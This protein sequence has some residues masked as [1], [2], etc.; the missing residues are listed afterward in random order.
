MREPSGRER[1][2]GFALPI[3]LGTVVLL[4]SPLYSE[5]EW[6]LAGAP[7]ALMLIA[8]VVA[9]IAAP[10]ALFVHHRTAWAAAVVALTA[11]TVVSVVAMERSEHSTNALILLWVWILGVPVVIVAAVT[12]QAI[13]T[14]EA[15]RRYRT[16]QR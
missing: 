2:G 11:V 14:V 4:A 1:L 10:I 13:G 7:I 16:L 6:H 5:S 12:K 9:P 15:W 8:L 3:V